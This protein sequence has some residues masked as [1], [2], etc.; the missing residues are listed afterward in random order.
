M[1]PYIY[2][3]ARVTKLI[4]QY[5]QHNTLVV[6]VDFDFTIY[7]PTTDSM[8]LDVVEI[9]LKAEQLNFTL[10]LWTANLARVPFI[11]DKC[12]SSG[13]NFKYVNKSPIHI[14][15]EIVKPHFNILLDDTAGLGQALDI[16]EQ[17]IQRL[18]E[19]QC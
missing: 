14:E 15:H 12:K 1:N 13:L 18:K 7:D 17:T 10:C 4:Q 2:S 5:K 19:R 3:E 8:Y 6:G 11:L 9:L 16:L